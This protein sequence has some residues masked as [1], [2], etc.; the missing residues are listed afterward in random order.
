MAVYLKPATTLRTAGPDTE[1]VTLAEAKA[2]LRVGS[3]DE[4]SYITA[5][6]PAARVACEEIARRSFIRQSFRSE[7]S[8]N[9][10]EIDSPYAS[11]SPAV[12]T[13]TL[14]PYLQLSYGPSCEVTALKCVNLAGAE[15]TTD[16]SAYRTGRNAAGG[17]IN[18]VAFPADATTDAVNP[19]AV[20]YDAGPDLADVNPAAKHAV[21]LMLTN[22]FENR[23]PVS[24]GPGAIEIPLTI[25]AILA[26]LTVPNI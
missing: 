20:E 14:W 15:I 1:I 12:E 4:D 8:C 26:P 5:L 3:T 21:L 9:D 24:I 2:Q 25:R 22:L 13:K 23:T 18:V 16:A 11:V 19:I 6:I 17:V 7:F 10:S